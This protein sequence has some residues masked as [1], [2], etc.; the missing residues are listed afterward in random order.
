M[1][2][3]GWLRPA[4]ALLGSLML[5][6]AIVGIVIGFAAAG[7]LRD[8]IPGI[9]ADAS[10][11]GGAAVA[12]SGGLILLGLGHLALALVIGQRRP[13]RV[14]RA[15]GV[16][17]GS[18]LTMVAVLGLASVAVSLAREV[19]AGPLLAAVPLLLALAVYATLSVS[20]LRANQE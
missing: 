9:T 5:V 10:V 1:P 13:S 19:S 17:V 8:Q 16:V 6:A 11:V 7:W 2:A 4:L 20:L 15:A 3:P 14:V 18:A 12:F